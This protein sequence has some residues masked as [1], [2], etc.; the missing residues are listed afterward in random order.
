MFYHKGW[1]IYLLDWSNY[2]DIWMVT[3]FLCLMFIRL[4]ANECKINKF[5]DDPLC[6]DYDNHFKIFYYRLFW[7]INSILI[8]MRRNIL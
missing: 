2:I 4:T 8:W 1:P 5:P 7:S 6:W 3:N